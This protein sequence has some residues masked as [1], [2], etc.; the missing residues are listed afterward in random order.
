[1]ERRPPAGR[2]A[3]FQ[4][5]R[6]RDAGGTAGKDAGA[7]SRPAKRR[8]GCDRKSSDRVMTDLL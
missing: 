3:A 4:A 5:A 7:P 1:M 8:A 2:S 6:Q